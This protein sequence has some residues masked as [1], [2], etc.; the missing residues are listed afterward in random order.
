[1]KMPLV[2]VIVPVYNVSEYLPN[3]LD[4]IK[5]QSFKDYEIIIINDSSPDNSAEI[6]DDFIHNNPELSISI[7]NHP[8]NKGISA[9]RNSG[10]RIAKGEYLYFID[11]DDDILPD[12]LE[13]LTQDIKNESLDV[14]IGENYIIDNNSKSKVCVDIASGIIE[15]DK[16]LKFFVEKKWYNQVWN[17]LYR[18]DFIIDNNLY[19]A[20]GLI[21]EDELFSFQVAS[22]A[23]RMLI[24][25]ECTYNYYIRPKSIISSVNNSSVRWHSFIKINEKIHDYI[26]EKHLNTD[27]HVGKYFFTNLLVCINGL[28]ATHSL[29]YKIFSRIIGLNISSPKTLYNKGLLARNEYLAYYYFVMPPVIGFMYYR[30]SSF[31]FKLKAS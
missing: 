7:I 28:S 15:D 27:I 31:L 21:L 19:F 20:E 30:L 17:K 6:I 9:A 22:C 29:K 26:Y 8:E 3:C 24:V 1:M 2:S 5:K 12:C 10:I 23:K 18:K 4:S 16:I 11:S 14:V 13:L 25:K